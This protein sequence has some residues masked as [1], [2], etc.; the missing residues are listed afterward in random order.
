MQVKNF[1]AYTEIVIIGQNPEL[2]DYSNPQGHEYGLAAYIQA[3]SEYGD[4][5]IKYVGVNPWEEQIMAKAEAQ[6]DALNARLSLGKLP[7]AF[8]SWKVGRPVYGSQAYED[9][10]QYDDYQLE[11]REEFAY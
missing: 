2:A 11:C 9:Y 5:R 3:V 7:V 6:A 8:D 10:G 4:T 1:T